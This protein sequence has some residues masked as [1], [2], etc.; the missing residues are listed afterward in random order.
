[1]STI[2]LVHSGGHYLTGA[3]VIMFS[4]R[5]LS[6]KISEFTRSGKIS[7]RSGKYINL[8]YQPTVTFAGSQFDPSRMC[9]LLG[10]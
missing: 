8:S 3:R 5:L 1:M 2:P 6:V 9:V 4:N 10:T 7:M